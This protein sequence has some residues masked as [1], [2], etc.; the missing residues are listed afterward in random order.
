MGSV[1]GHVVRGS[2]DRRSGGPDLPGGES[3]TATPRRLRRAAPAGRT[4]SGRRLRAVHGRAPAR[5]LSQGHPA[6]PSCRRIKGSSPLPGV[7]RLY[8]PLM[9][10]GTL[11]EL[12]DAASAGDKQAWEELIRRFGG[13]VWSIARAHG[14]SR[15]DAADVS[16]T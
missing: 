14:L 16:Q 13:L 1:V 3:D 10:Q 7:S 4:A 15:T 5:D 11:G 2:A 9:E 8:Y 12:V 6:R